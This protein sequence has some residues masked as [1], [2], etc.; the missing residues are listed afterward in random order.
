MLELLTPQN[1][2]PEQCL[3]VVWIEDKQSEMLSSPS[4][5]SR[6][7]AIWRAWEP[8]DIAVTL[9]QDLP[10]IYSQ[11]RKAK[12]YN[13]PCLPADG[14]L[15]DF[16]LLGAGK[17]A[18]SRILN[19][20]DIKPIPDPP[21]AKNV[22][23]KPRAASAVELNDFNPLARE[24][25]AAGLTAAVLTALN[26]DYHPAVIVPYT[27]YQEQLS[28]QRALIRLLVP[29]SLVISQKSELD[30]G[31][32]SLEEKLQQF[33][34]DYRNNLAVWASQDIVSVPSGEVQRLRSLAESRVEKNTEQVMWH[35]D[36][37]IVIDGVYGRRRISCGSLWYRIDGT[38]PSLADVNDWLNKMPVPSA[39]YSAAVKLADEYWGYSETETSRYRYTLS[40]LIRSLKIASPSES[41]TI[42]SYI[43]AFCDL[44]GIN[45]KMALESPSSVRINKDKCVPHL[46][47]S[48]APREVRRLAVFM[49]LAMEYAARWASTQNETDELWKFRRII[50]YKIEGVNDSPIKTFD[51]INVGNINGLNME[52]LTQFMDDLGYGALGI[53]KGELLLHRVQVSESDM[54]QRLDPVPEQLLTTEERFSGE[55]LYQRLKDIGIDLGALIA[56]REEDGIEPDERREVQYFAR[57]IGYPPSEW[58]EWMRKNYV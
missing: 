23:E 54:A 5:L 43:K 4:T 57:D 39:V 35:N 55:R 45:P 22:T 52:M 13:L 11:R 19:E 14:F 20:A 27:A 36:D 53:Q 28:R 41:T 3:K 47:V 30:L 48:G 51:E 25:E 37:F 12:I 40:R 50:D 21:S 42:E 16:N 44:V 18:K 1:E 46:L 34:D 56:N 32:E 17:A 33:A 58:P 24:A 26:F 38:G 15:A 31:K 8:D 7:F 9:R 6:Y 29:I 49:L 2:R 10:K